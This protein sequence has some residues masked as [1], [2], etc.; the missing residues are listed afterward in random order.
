MP[1]DDRQFGCILMSLAQCFRSKNAD[2]HTEFINQFETAQSMADVFNISN[3]L[4]EK[5]TPYA[6]AYNYWNLYIRSIDEGQQKVDE[7]AFRWA[8]NQKYKSS[9]HDIAKHINWDQL[10]MDTIKLAVLGI[11]EKR[12][13]HDGGHLSRKLKSM[14]DEAVLRYVLVAKIHDFI[15]SE[16]AKVGYDPVAYKNKITTINKELKVNM[17]NMPEKSHPY[18]DSIIDKLEKLDVESR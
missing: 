16:F 6:K 18:R 12:D 1:E 9:K 14:T 13:I 11:I 3:S 8:N 15:S 17:D 5:S 4:K 10:N 2:T 7:M